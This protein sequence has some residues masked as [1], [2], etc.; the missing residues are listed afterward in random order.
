MSKLKTKDLLGQLSDLEAS[1]N[2][3]SFEELNVEEAKHLKNSFNRF[4]SQLNNKIFGTDETFEDSQ[5]QRKNHIP[6]QGGQDN[7]LIAHVSHEIRTPLNGII[8]FAN[9]L[10][11]D[12]LTLAQ[13]RKVDAI[14]SASYSLMEII[15]EVLEYSKLTTDLEEFEKVD[16]NIHGILKDVMFLC[17]TLI[18]DKTV[19]L[20][21]EIAPNVPKVLVGDP[22]KLSQILLNLMGNAIKFVEKG[23]ITLSVKL[24]EQEKE[25]YILQFAVQDTG[26]GIP[27]NQLGHIFESYK[28]AE[29]TTFQKYGGSG[30]GLS[31]VKEI[32]E[33]LGG[34]ISVT[35]TVGVGSMFKF[36]IPFGQGN[37]NNIPQ[38]KP[39]S[40]STAKGKELL[41]GTKILIFEDNELN[42]HLI[43]EQLNKWDCITYVTENRN[44]GLQIL[45]TKAIDIVLMDLKMPEMNGFEISK[46]IRALND[47]KISQIPI[48]AF[49]AD[50]TAQDKERC[51][52]SGINDFLLKPYTLNELM[53]KLLK[54]KKERNLTEASL[55]LLKQETISA[56]ESTKETIDLNTLLKDCYGE[57]DMLQEL[58]RLFKQNI[59]EFI[60][61]VKI[62]ITNQA[63]EDIYLA[64]H[65]IKAGLALMNTND[66]K[67]IVV[68]IEDQAKNSEMEKVKLLFNQFLEEFPLKESLIDQELARLK[69]G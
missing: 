63:F 51:Y 15:N 23:H 45:K 52:E 49:S 54:R 25:N 39:K 48:I 68:A 11:E 38:N 26:I 53:I 22:S 35:S 50:F 21:T 24:K 47:D 46:S 66:L 18:I 1:L 4:K 27:E 10:R 60:G 12:N 69:Q 8:G 55:K 37:P 20:N 17:Q 2:G 61:A 34:K 43:S 7:K 33:K 5:P 59:Y 36:Y 32:I 62:A 40:I 56:F 41:G 9:L 28:Q 16:F 13:E 3:F 65:K 14:Q 30:L 57:L 64:A 31:I 44:E 29:N 19:I 67:Q 42:R 58:V 6:Q